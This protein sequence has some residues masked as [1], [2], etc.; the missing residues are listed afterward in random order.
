[1][2]NEFKRKIILSD[3]QKEK[4]HKIW[5]IYGNRGKKCNHNQH[6]FIQNVN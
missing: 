3:S 4:L 5:F 6:R 1:M 2:A